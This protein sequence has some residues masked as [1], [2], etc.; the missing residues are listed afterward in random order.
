MKAQTD[1]KNKAQSELIMETDIVLNKLIDEAYI[2]A[3]AFFRENPETAPVLLDKNP[4]KNV[5]SSLIKTGLL[6]SAFAL[7]DFNI[8]VNKNV[9]LEALVKKVLSE[10]KANGIMEIF[11]KDQLEASQVLILEAAE[12]LKLPMT[13][14]KTKSSAEGAAKNSW[15]L[16]RIW[17]SK[18]QPKVEVKDAEKE[19]AE[20]KAHEQA[21]KAFLDGYIKFQAATPAI[22]DAQ[23][24]AAEQV[25]S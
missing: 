3:V 4:R 9:D 18:E 5:L 13:K 15:L 21:R 12:K 8:C 19:A 14:K 1:H 17:G 2:G 6:Q 16:A 10:G 23:P 24:A 11:A 20:A 7:T 22:Q 25:A